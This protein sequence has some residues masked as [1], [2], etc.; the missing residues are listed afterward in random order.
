MA[1][2]FLAVGCLYFYVLV[3]VDPAPRRL[4]HIARLGV[5]FIV[6]PFHAFF[7]VALMEENTVLAGTYYR[8]LGDPYHVGLLADQQA[9]AGLGWTLGEVPIVLVLIAVF[10]SWVRDDEREARRRDRA[11]DRALARG[12]EDELAAYNAWLAQ[13][14]SRSQQR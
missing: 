5:L 3:G 10:I 7:S 1:A 13:L 14:N 9:G 12:E 8:A 11:A 2:H 6:M 4:P